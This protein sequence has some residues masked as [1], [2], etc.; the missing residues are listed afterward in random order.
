LTKEK[1]ASERNI[2]G[3][4]I[5]ERAEEYPTNY[6]WMDSNDYLHY[7]VYIGMVMKKIV[8]GISGSTVI[9]KNFYILMM[10]KKEVVNLFPSCC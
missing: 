4:M 7:V 10:M 3:L 6:L 1:L 2:A 9:K 5:N 8:F